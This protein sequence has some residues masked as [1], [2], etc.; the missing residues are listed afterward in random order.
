MIRTF[1]TSKEMLQ[2]F[3]KSVELRKTWGNAISK[4]IDGATM[5]KHG[6]ETITIVD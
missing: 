6:I 5:K 3:K 2:A 1:K 4:K